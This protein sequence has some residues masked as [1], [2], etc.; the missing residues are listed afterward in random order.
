MNPSRCLSLVSPMLT[1]QTHFLLVFTTS[2]RRWFSS[3]DAS[4][5]LVPVQNIQGRSI[6]T[7]ALASPISRAS[8]DATLRQPRWHAQPYHPSDEPTLLV[9]HSATK[10]GALNPPMRSPTRVFARGN[11]YPHPDLCSLSSAVLKDPRAPAPLLLEV[12]APYPNSTWE[13][14]CPTLA[15]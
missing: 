3:R 2:A 8:T 15:T 4:R 7:I 12:I 6:C 11:V 9:V 14:Q 10:G 5:L 13:N 1:T